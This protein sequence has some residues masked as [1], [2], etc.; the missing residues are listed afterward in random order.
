[1]EIEEAFMRTNEIKYRQSYDAPFLQEPLLSSYGYLGLND[2]ADK[3]MEGTFECPA[4]TDQ[5]A[6][7]LLKHL[8]MNDEARAA[9]EAPTSI[10]IVT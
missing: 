6:A 7:K 10:D 3:V 5:Y 9:P 1:V 8:K 2:N 4:G